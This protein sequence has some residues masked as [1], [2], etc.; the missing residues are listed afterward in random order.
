ME[1]FLQGL[2]VSSRGESLQHFK[3]SWAH[4]HEP[5]KE[6]LDAVKVCED[7]ASDSAPERIFFPLSHFLFSYLRQLSQRC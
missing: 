4:E 1:I 3:K 6:L 7:L 2:V 5:V